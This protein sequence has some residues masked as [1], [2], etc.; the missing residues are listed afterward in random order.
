VQIRNF[1]RRQD[2][3]AAVLTEF[4]ER[5]RFSTA[6]SSRAS[7]FSRVNRFHR[8]A[9]KAIIGLKELAQDLAKPSSV[10]RT[11]STRPAQN[12]TQAKYRTVP[13][14][15]AR[16]AKCQSRVMS[17]VNASSPTT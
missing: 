3:R 13:S 4:L 1:R 10:S 14:S 6:P 12:H 11:C 7:D 15:D 5:D 9:C 16:N 17:I 8:F 2:S